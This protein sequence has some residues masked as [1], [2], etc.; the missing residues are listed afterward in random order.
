MDARDAYMIAESVRHHGDLGEAEVSARLVVELRLLVTY[1]TDLV[2]NR[3]R[4]VNRVRDVLS[5]ARS[6]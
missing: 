5:W 1:R 6:Y 2:G 3:V 4:M